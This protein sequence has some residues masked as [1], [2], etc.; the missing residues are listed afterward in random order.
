[1]VF[2][3]VVMPGD[4]DGCALAR[5]IMARWPNSKILLTSGFSGTRLAD[6]EGLGSNVRLLNKPYRKDDLTRTIREVLDDRFV[7][8]K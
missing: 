8:A 6:V 5:E 3:D 7:G 1:M 2:S 4:M